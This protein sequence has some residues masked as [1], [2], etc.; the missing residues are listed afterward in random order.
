MGKV[1]Y[2]IIM[3]VAIA[4]TITTAAAKESRLT[5]V[6][7][8]SDADNNNNNNK[9]P[10]FSSGL[11]TLDKSCQNYITARN[12]WYESQLQQLIGNSTL[13]K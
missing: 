4:S 12:F 2:L 13:Q 1:S 5:H 7:E 3:V 8:A 9:S 10:W 11:L 6:K